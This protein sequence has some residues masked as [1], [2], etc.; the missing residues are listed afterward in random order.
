MHDDG[1]QAIVVSDDDGNGSDGDDNDARLVPVVMVELVVCTMAGT[2]C[3]C[4]LLLCL[5]LW[6][7]G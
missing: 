3:S 5:Y 2:I 4:P 7:P 1:G 6:V